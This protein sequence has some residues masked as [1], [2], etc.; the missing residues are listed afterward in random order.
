MVHQQEVKSVSEYVAY[1]EKITAQGKYWFRGVAKADYKPAPGTVWKNVNIG[2]EGGLEH[3]FLMSYQSYTDRNFSAWDLYALMQHHGLPTRLLDWSE[4][5]LVALF[6]ALTSEPDSD[7]D[8]AIWVLNPY[9]LNKAT[10]GFNSLF[11]PSIL[12]NREISKDINLDKYL[13]INLKPGNID[14]L[15][16]EKPIAINASQHIRRVSAQKGCFTLHGFSNNS[17][18]SYLEGTEHCRLVTVKIS[19]Q[20]E[21]MK[22]INSLA[23]LGIDEEFIYQDLDSLCAKIKRQWHIPL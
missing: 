23:S 21:R 20:S 4:S 18:D 11:C 7:S 8:R 10:I 19:S 16:P 3:Q 15:I 6:F 1:I 9:E 22:M 13:P 2:M 17:I 12:A 5:A 14:R